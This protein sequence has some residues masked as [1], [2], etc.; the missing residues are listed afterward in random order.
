MSAWLT[1]AGI[2]YGSLVFGSQD[3]QPGDRV[4]DDG[5]LLAYPVMGSESFPLAMA[6]TEFHFLL[7]VRKSLVA[8]ST[9]SSCVW[10][11]NVEELPCGELQCG[12]ADPRHLALLGE[13]GVR[14]CGRR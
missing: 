10:Q 11:F 13:G 12:P 14:G 7:L 9:L 4:I 5:D 1:G 8:K 3:G 2:F 6:L